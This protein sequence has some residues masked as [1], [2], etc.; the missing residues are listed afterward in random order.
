ME[1]STKVKCLTILTIS[2]ILSVPLYFAAVICINVNK[3]QF[4]FITVDT[5]ITGTLPQ[6]SS[7]SSLAKGVCKWSFCV[8]C[9][10]TTVEE[11]YG[12]NT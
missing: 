12:V 5:Y 9:V 3:E 4:N 8:R 11:I 10:G 7:G 6:I 2:T 1:R